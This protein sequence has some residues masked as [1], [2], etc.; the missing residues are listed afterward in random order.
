MSAAELAAFERAIDTGR[1]YRPKKKPAAAVGDLTA[2]ERRAAARKFGAVS[3]PVKDPGQ[4]KVMPLT[5]DERRR[6]TLEIVAVQ[7]KPGSKR[8]SKM[9]SRGKRK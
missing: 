6:R 7:R 2:A 9:G 8:T 4:V 1:A 5:D 3:K